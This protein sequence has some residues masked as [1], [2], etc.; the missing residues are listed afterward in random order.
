MNWQRFFS[1]R[2]RDRFSWDKVQVVPNFCSYG[3]KSCNFFVYKYPFH[4]KTLKIQKNGKNYC[5]KI[6]FCHEKGTFT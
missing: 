1:L 5:K 3:S 2:L 6:S 4:A